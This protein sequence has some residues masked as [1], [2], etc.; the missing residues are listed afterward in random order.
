MIRH[1]T[2]VAPPTVLIYLAGQCITHWMQ[3]DDAFP[4]DC[5]RAKYC[6]LTGRAIKMTIIKCFVKPV[7]ENIRKFK[8]WTQPTVSATQFLWMIVI[9]RRTK[10]INALWCFG[11]CKLSSKFRYY[12][13]SPISYLS[14]VDVLLIYTI[15]SRFPSVWGVFIKI[16]TKNSSPIH[17]FTYM[18]RMCAKQIE[19]VGKIFTVI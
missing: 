2:L 14:V 17:L 11:N 19:Q 1:A 16:W 15:F 18:H 7:I 10:E 12:N 13:T 5:I 8:V 6:N 9:S 4:F 3:R